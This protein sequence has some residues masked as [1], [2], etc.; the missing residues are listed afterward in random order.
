MNT[1]LETFDLKVEGNQVVE[2]VA[3]IFHTVL[4]HRCLGKFSFNEDGTYY[5]KGT[6][7][8]VEVDCNFID[9]TYI[10]CSSETLN[11]RLKDTIMQFSNELRSLDGLTLQSG[12]I[13]LEFFQKKRR[14]VWQFYP[15]SIPWEM[16]TINVELIK[17][18]SE[19][20][21]IKFREEISELLTEKIVLVTE[22]LNSP[23][24]V[25]DMPK[26]ED[27]GSVF[28]TSFPDMTAYNFKVSY[29][30]QNCK[31]LLKDTLKQLLYRT[32]LN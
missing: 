32:V 26:K 24:Y 4:F 8:F 12:R 15:G 29:I 31:S 9:L 19:L 11:N 17:H 28:D 22:I 23:R 7:G 10:A 25:P 13:S 14:P 20:Q 5:P 18:S 1:Q 27:L 16:W 21:H 3:S 30:T 6:I 2:A